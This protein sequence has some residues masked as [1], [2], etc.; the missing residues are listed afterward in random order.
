MNKLALIARVLL[1]G[2]FVVFGINKF[3]GF[4][5]P[6]EIADEGAARFIGALVNSSVRFWKLLAVTEIVGGL[7][8]LSGL[9]VPLGL[10]VLAPVVINILLFHAAGDTAGLPIALVFVALEAYLGF[11]AY[12]SA[13]KPLLTPGSGPC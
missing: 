8:V 3:A 1:G 9:F 4:M 12:R 5:P 13:F 2:G 11:F 6:P 7:M 10:V